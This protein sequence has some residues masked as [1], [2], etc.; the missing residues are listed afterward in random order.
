MRPGI[1]LTFITMVSQFKY[2][3]VYVAL[4]TSPC[5]RSELYL[6]CRKLIFKTN[7][8]SILRINSLPTPVSLLIDYSINPQSR[9]FYGI[10]GSNSIKFLWFG[11]RQ[12]I[13]QISSG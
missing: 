12:R 5:Q 6:G 10:Q 2:K 8:V 13:N 1:V 3:H 7:I 9:Q 4:L 11:E